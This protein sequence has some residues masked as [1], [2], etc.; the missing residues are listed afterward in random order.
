MKQIV[1]RCYGDE[2]S[3]VMCHNHSLFSDMY[4]K[5]NLA[6]FPQDSKQK[7]CKYIQMWVKTLRF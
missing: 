7:C 4:A 1:F 3:H 2:P 5:W 6:D